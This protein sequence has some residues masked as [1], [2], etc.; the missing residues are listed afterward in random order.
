MLEQGSDSMAGVSAVPAR[1]SSF[2]C[3]M[4]IKLVW[5]A[6]DL[7]DM[8]VRCGNMMR[9]VVVADNL[10]SHVEMLI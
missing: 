1:P 4:P 10:G 9:P 2:G 7:G 3:P 5:F 8:A 6:L